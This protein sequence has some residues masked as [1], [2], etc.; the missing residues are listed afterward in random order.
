[1]LTAV[2]ISLTLIV[3]S[4]QPLPSPAQTL[5]RAGFQARRSPF[6]SAPHETILY[7]K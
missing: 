2:S 6:K 3:T 7:Q 4:L 1:L 5:A